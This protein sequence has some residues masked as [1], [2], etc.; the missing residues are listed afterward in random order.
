MLNS[1]PERLA[2]VFGEQEGPRGHPLRGDKIQ[3]ER[4]LALVTWHIPAEVPKQ[5][6][7]LQ[8]TMFTKFAKPDAASLQNM[9][10]D[11]A[12]RR[13]NFYSLP[14]SR[15]KVKAN[16]RKSLQKVVANLKGDL[17]ENLGVAFRFLA[18]QYLGRFQG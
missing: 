6:T 10:S 15:Q 17:Q 1:Q 2:V 8:G 11:V 5:A 18:V 3:E 7:K 9:S 16:Q 4:G 14:S 12:S 13:S